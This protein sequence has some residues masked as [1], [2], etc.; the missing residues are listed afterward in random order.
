MGGL[1]RRSFI[2][3]QERGSAPEVPWHIHGQGILS[4]MRARGD[5]QL[6]TRTGRQIFWVM[7]NML[8]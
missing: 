3:S 2:T 7:H 6:Y 4:L 1:E 5:R 8:D